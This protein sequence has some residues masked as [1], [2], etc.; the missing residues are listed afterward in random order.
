MELPLT[1]PIFYSSKQG[2]EKSEDVEG[3][4]LSL[5]GLFL[6]SPLLYLKN[7]ISRHRRISL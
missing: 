5:S 4:I 1:S 2:P 3:M 7:R 6:S